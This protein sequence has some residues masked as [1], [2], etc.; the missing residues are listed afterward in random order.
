MEPMRFQS[1]VEV[2]NGE[3]CTEDG[4]PK[5]RASYVKNKEIQIFTAADAVMMWQTAILW[6]QNK[7]CIHCRQPSEPS[8]TDFLIWHKGRG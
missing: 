3:D 6:K 1:N 5:A 7:P 2:L 4:G 8:M